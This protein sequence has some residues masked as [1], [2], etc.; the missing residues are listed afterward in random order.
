ME[1]NAIRTA[2]E[3]WE[4]GMAYKAI[5]EDSGGQSWW[6]RC[7]TTGM[8]TAVEDMWDNVDDK[9]GCKDGDGMGKYLQG[10]TANLRAYRC[11]GI[12]GMADNISGEASGG[13]A[14]W[15]RCRT[16]G[17]DTAVEEMRDGNR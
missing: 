3:T 1:D 12:M 8:D 14:Q 13:R 2:T 6:R 17:M 11:S 16:T 4:V 15:W 10:M 9:M 5:G 7:R